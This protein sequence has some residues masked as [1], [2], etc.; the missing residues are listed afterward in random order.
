MKRELLA[1]LAMVKADFEE[2]RRQYTEEDK[3]DG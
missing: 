3:L 1:V 2:W